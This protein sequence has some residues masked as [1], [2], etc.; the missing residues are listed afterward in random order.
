MICYVGEWDRHMRNLSILTRKHKEGEKDLWV[1]TKSACNDM[2]CLVYCQ[3][4]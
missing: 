1:S 2:D 3:Q 4:Q